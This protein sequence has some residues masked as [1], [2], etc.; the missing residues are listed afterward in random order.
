MYSFDTLAAMSNRQALIGMKAESLVRLRESGFNV[1]WGF[2][3]TTDEVSSFTDEE[4]ARHIDEK[5]EYAVRSSGTSEDLEGLSFAGQY[6]T[7]LKVSGLANLRAAIEAC[8]A[9][10]RKESVVAYAQHSGLDLAGGRM[11]VIVQQMVDSE[12][13]GV[14]FSI[15]A[16]SGLDHEI[17]VEAV[18]GLGES[19][20][21]GRVTPDYYAYNWY[22]EKFSAYGGETLTRDEV[23][24][25]AET[26]LAIQVEYGFPV[27][28][29]WAIVGDEVFILQSRP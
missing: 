19:L 9:S 5:A 1:P 16:L 13:A 22:D 2:V 28:V 23:K 15:D 7:F 17:M 6:D 24:R 26:V 10:V 12:K 27:D 29:E 8:A 25:L 11:A 20:V 21:S 4:L 14:A 3:V 18:H